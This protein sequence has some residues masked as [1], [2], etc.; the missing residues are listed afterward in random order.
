MSDAATRAKLDVIRRFNEAFNRHD[1]DGLMALMTSDCVFDNTL[2]ARDGE[3]VE[4]AAGCGP[5]GGKLA[6]VKG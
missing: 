6:Y 5:S 3:R 1:V 4:G 2:P